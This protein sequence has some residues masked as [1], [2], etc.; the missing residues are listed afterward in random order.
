[1]FADS[2]AISFTLPDAYDAT[3]WAPSTLG[4]ELAASFVVTADAATEVYVDLLPTGSPSGRFT[5]FDGTP[6]ADAN[7][8][9][10]TAP[11]PAARSGSPGSTPAPTTSMPAQDRQRVRF[12]VGRVDGR[13]DARPHRDRPDRVDLAVLVAPNGSR[14]VDITVPVG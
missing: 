2:Y 13:L 10:G 9:T 5:A 14:T 4:E 6:L 12:P 11:T 7:V 3:P 1:V 8:S